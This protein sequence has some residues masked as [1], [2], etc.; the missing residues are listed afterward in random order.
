[1]GTDWTPTFVGRESKRS[2]GRG[3]LLWGVFARARMEWSER[4]GTDLTIDDPK[5]EMG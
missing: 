3:G 5:W 2:P 4:V 1:M